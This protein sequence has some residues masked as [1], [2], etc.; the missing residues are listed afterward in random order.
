MADRIRF[1]TVIASTVGTGC[2][3][4][5][6]VA[7]REND[8]QGAEVGREEVLRYS[9]TRKH[10]RATARK[11]IRDGVALGTVTILQPFEYVRRTREGD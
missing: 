7:E 6:D 9:P 11:L 4:R 10:A 2:Y 1:K 8:G 5:Y 3:L